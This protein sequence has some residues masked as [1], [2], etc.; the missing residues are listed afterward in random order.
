MTVTQIFTGATNAGLP[1]GSAV[2]ANADSICFATPTLAGDEGYEISLAI[3]VILPALG[4]RRVYEAIIDT[5]HMVSIPAGM[6]RSGF[7]LRVYV[8]TP[9]QI[10]LEIYAI[11]GTD[12]ASGAEYVEQFT[13]ADLVADA[14]A[15]QHNLDKDFPIVQ[16]YDG[17]GRLSDRAD[18]VN[19]DVNTIEL[20]FSS[21]GGA[22]AIVGTY[23]VR[24]A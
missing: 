19:V 10:T 18:V 15:I 13:A 4:E 11:A 17:D 23:T 3:V 22:A 20:D 16:L 8:A 9:Y 1:T 21:T 5:Q 14:I 2:F 24:V 6:G 7:D 12:N